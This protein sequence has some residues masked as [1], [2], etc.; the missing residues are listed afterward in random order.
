MVPEAGATTVMEIMADAPLPSDAAVQVTFGAPI[1]QVN[2]ALLALTNEPDEGSVPVT[3]TFEASPGPLFVTTRSN[4]TVLPGVA[5]FGVAVIVSA[6][7]A[8][9]V[10]ITTDRFAVALHA[11]EVAVTLR[12]TLPMGPAVNWMAF[13]PWPPVMVPFEID[14]AYVA[15]AMLVAEAELFVEFAPTN[16]GAVMAI[17]VGVTV[18]LV[19]EV[20]VQ[21]PFATET[22]METL[23]EDGAVKVMVFVP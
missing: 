14:Q 21:L 22:E 12:V 10:L 4:E 11:P 17:D 15:P 13:V 16:G 7:S 6:R 23:P 5:T 2:V 8:L 3:V 19:L 1:V 20:E 9:V 18:T